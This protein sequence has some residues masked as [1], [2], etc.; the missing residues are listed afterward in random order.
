MHI[1]NP[2]VCM[3]CLSPV[4]TLLQ[5]LGNSTPAQTCDDTLLTRKLFFA[6]STTVLSSLGSFVF[7]ALSRARL[8]SSSRFR[9]SWRQQRAKTLNLNPVCMAQ[10]PTSARFSSLSSTGSCG[11]MILGRESDRESVC[12]CVL[13]DASG[14]RG[15][16]VKRRGGGGGV[17]SGII[18]KRFRPPASTLGNLFAGWRGLQVVWG[19]A[20]GRSLEGYDPEGLKL[21][22]FLK[23][24]LYESQV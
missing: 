11:W 13:Q 10:C 15:V 5:Q 19:R 16:Q 1:Q 9:R 21:Y 7:L 4:A 8:A 24:T 14:C 6:G 22:G 23:G 18:N 3:S 2:S 17:K 12:V 20:S